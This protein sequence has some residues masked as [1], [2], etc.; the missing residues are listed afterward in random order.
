MN[1]KITDSILS[2]WKSGRKTR[3][4]S[5]GWISG[6]AVCCPFNGESTDSR[7]RGGL[8]VNAN[9]AVSYSCFNCG[10]KTSF[11]PGR[12]L[13]YKFRKLLSWLGLSENQIQELVIEAIRLK[14]LISLTR[15]EEVADSENYEYKIRPLPAEALSF[16]ALYEFYALGEKN[17]PKYFVDAVQYVS[18]RKIDMQ[19]YEFFYSPEVENKLSHRVIIPFKYQG[20]TVGWTSRAMVDGIVPKYHSSHEPNFVFNIDEQL[21]KNKFVIVC[22][23]VFDAMAID[24]VAVLGSECSEQQANI[25]DN[26]GKEVIVVPDFDRHLSKTGKKVWPG[27]KMIDYAMEYGWS[28]SFPV[29]RETCKDIGEAIVKYGKLFVLKT[30]LDSKQ[31][32]R[33]KLE[34]MKKRVFNE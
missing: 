8:I 2:Q 1:N 23:G 22:E 15:P 31:Q 28:V 21:P 26:L 11:H 27:A 30:I 34:L 10:Y 14:E 25:I 7:G 13:S 24:G 12:P 20:T 5:S 3:T 16:M 29:W 18:D 6:N 17:F 19:R 33:L 9:S 32:G 4:S